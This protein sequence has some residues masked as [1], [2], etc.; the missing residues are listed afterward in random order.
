MG[1]QLMIDRQ[2]LQEARQE[3]G[4]K[5]A[6]WRKTRQLIQGDLARQVRSSRSTVAM[7]ERGHQVV[8]RVFWRQCE[9]LL[10]AQGELIA[11]YD[12]YRQLETR[13]R[14]EK[15]EAARRARWGTAMDGGTMADEP[16]ADL[17]PEG[18]PARDD[19]RVDATGVDTQRRSLLASI[20]GVVAGSGLLGLT[21]NT[22]GRRV[23]ASDVARIEAVTTLYRS[24]DYEI[25][26]GALCT[27]V[28]RFAEATSVLLNRAD[29]GRWATSL[30]TAVAGARQLAGWTA[31]DAGRH[32]DAGRHWLAAERTA[33]AVGD[34]QLAARIR[35]CQARQ[36]QH[37]R[38]NHDALAT[39]RLAH[40]ALGSEATPALLAMLRGTEAASLAA[41]GEHSA[42]TTALQHASGHFEDIDPDQEPAWMRFYE[43]GELLAQYG[44]VHRDLARH[45]HRHADTA[46]EW[47][48]AA[49]STFGPQN[50]RSTVL[51][52]IGLCSALALAG[53]PDQAVAVGTDV[54]HHERHLTSRRVRD[55]VR[56]LSRDIPADTRH[57]GLADFR[58]AITRIP[59]AAA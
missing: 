41:L 53:E 12:A 50:V 6:T 34:R 8:D 5:L 15:A 44:R 49:I 45:D 28:G 35:Y 30:A 21:M 26:G 11:A 7:V 54:I 16:D 27:E 42:A 38:H 19:H 10:D 25:G 51:N 47:T 4:R 1:R 57:S 46:V 40:D 14:V 20:A 29:A 31:F 2:Q 58:H 52:K 33:V 55:R 18:E 56:N 13:H 48:Q 43:R 17:L 23:G 3:L 59:S 36:F 39:I 37:L 22:V 24:V 32:S 9:S